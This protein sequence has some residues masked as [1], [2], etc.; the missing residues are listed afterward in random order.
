MLNKKTLVF[1]FKVDNNFY[2]YDVNTN[3]ILRVSKN[4]YNNEKYVTKLHEEYRKR[5]GLFE[6]N[7]FIQFCIGSNRGEQ[8]NI[9][10]DLCENKVQKLILVISEDCN[11]RCRYCV[12]SG[13]FFFRRT[14]RKNKM[15]ENVAIR[16]IDFFISHSINSEYRSITFYGGE[17][18]LNFELIK[19]CVEYVRK[20]NIMNIRFS[21]ISNGTLLNPSIMKFLVENDIT[22][23]ISLDGPKEIHDKER[24]F[25]NG[26]GSFNKIFSNLRKFYN[27]Y[28]EY[29]KKKITFNCTLT[30]KESLKKIYKFFVELPIEF[31]KVDIHLVGTQDSKLNKKYK[32]KNSFIEEWKELKKLYLNYLIMKKPPDSK[33][34]IFLRSLYEKPL[35]RIHLRESLILKNKKSLYPHGTCIPGAF[36]IFVTPDGTIYPCEKMD[37]EFVSIGNI[38]K[39]FDYKKIIKIVEEFEDMLNELCQTCWMK[40]I[41]SACLATAHIGKNLSIER[42]KQWCDSIRKTFEEA[43]KDYVYLIEKDKK[44]LDY[45]FFIKK[46]EVFKNE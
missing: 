3:L 45:Y 28:P 11:L 7:S 19:K 9:I 12:Y 18:F 29:F 34:M 42:Q 36:E 46:Q 32:F 17:P 41:C 21:I 31:L 2:I 15:G 6:E 44:I 24:V 37:T 33:E 5:Y 27:F 8:K 22:L 38:F 16:A 1:K 40:R 14:H 26:R 20:K 35:R 10:K 4:I 30:G 39:G 25:K 43:I 23:T 13:N